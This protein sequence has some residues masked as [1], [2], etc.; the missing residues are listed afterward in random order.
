MTNGEPHYWFSRHARSIIVLIITLAILGIYL[1]FTIPVAVFP[2]T[3]FPRILIAVDNGV[4]PIDQMMVTVTRP[5]EEAV[6]SVPGLQQV[7]SI[8]SRGSAEVDLFFDWNVDMF[9]TLQYVNSALS[10]V[11]RE[12][13]ASAKVEGHRMTFASFPILGYSLTS[14]TVPQT[15][16]W[17]MAT[18]ELKP[19]LNRLD[20]VARVI[21]QGGQEPEFHIVPDPAKLLQASVTVPDLLE[22]VRRTNLIDS[23]GL[24]ERNHQLYLGLVNGQVRDPQQIGSI[25]IKT[26]AA[27]VPVRVGDVATVEQSVRPLYTVVTANEKPAVLLS[28]NR[29]PDSNTVQVADE[30]HDEVEQIRKSLPPGVEI[31]PYYDQS[32]IVTESIRSVRDAILIGL[33]LASIILV[34]FLHDWGTSVVAGLVI[35]VTIAV[36]FIALKLIGQSFNLMTLGGLAAAVGLV[37][38]DA[39]VVVE[40]IVLHRDAGQ[41][42]LQAIHSALG[43]ITIPLIGSTI[44]PIVVFLPLISITGVTGTFF[45]ALAVTMSVSLLTSLALALTWTPSLSQFLIKRHTDEV[46]TDAPPEPDAE[47]IRRLMEVEE[48]SLGGFFLKVIRFH[49]HWLRRA[50]ERPRWL[51]AMSLALIVIA[52]VCYNYSGSDLLPAMDEGGFIIDYIMPAGSS[53]AETN[54]VVRHIEQMLHDTPEVESTSRRTGL[55]LGLAAVTE[56]NTGDVSVKLKSSRGRDIDEIM[57]EVRAKI[58]TQEPAIDVEFI[59]VL[60]DMIGDLTS[61]PEPVQIKLFSQ[62]PAVLEEWAPKVADAIGKNKGVVDVLNG[63]D[64]TISGPAVMFQV[65]PS[66]AARAGFT[67][68]EVATDAAAILEGEPSPIPVVSHDRAYTLRVRF[69]AAR[70]ATLE[71][72]RDTLLVSSTGKTATLGALATLTDLP[73]QTEIRRENLQRDVAVTARLEGVDLG[74]G[75][76]SVQKSVADLHLPSSIRVVYGGTYQEQQKSFRDL[77]FVLIL[78][79]VLVFIVLLFEFRTFAAP[80]AILSSALLSTSGVFLALFITRTTFNISSFMGLIMVVGIVAKNGILLLDAEQKFRAAGLSL[81]DSVIQ[82]SRRRLRPIVMTALAAMA[83]MLPLAFA[84]GAGSQM[85]K[86]LAIAV[87]GGVLISMLPSLTITPAV[88]LSVTRRA[89]RNAT[90]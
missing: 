43:E 75:I 35:P 89:E 82:A 46:H 6:N 78:A 12:L 16:L 5:I 51:A 15:Q 21:V 80:L 36:T 76:A 34:V 26:T 7:R 45:R 73:G 25:V 17:E 13:P 71:A 74:T 81:E 24:L 14:D 22:A 19:R 10:S 67:P 63:I 9:Q 39:I 85:L 27:G 20:G 83:G 54:R 1:A 40:N 65:D 77:V 84:L 58:K 2:A 70:R 47:S 37:I 3:N 41:T 11:Q 60:Q 23:P 88:H 32:D 72:M 61:A 4:M 29:Q 38:D 56:A 49:E 62:D 66:V 52:Y 68:E 55:Q 50:L 44:T 57:E 53:L 79:V 8:T 28:I 31:H 48:A 86:P 18:Y 69:P 30:V 33:I 87:I 42:R 90:V 64:N 59:Q